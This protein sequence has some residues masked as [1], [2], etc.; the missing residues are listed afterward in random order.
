MVS[1]WFNRAQEA[2]ADAE[3]RWAEEALAEVQAAEELAMEEVE[4]QEALGILGGA[5]GF[6]GVHNP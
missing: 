2:T 4:A 1:P 3:H 6:Q 5:P